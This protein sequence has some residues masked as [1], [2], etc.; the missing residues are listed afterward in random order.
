MG[1]LIDRVYRD[2]QQAS[3]DFH[4]QAVKLLTDF[5][6]YLWMTTERKK[7]VR[8]NDFAPF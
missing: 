6:F 3:V 8:A 4:L 5:L 1:V 7:F 2:E